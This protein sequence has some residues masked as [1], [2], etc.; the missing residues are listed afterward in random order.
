MKI[1]VKITLLSAVAMIALIISVGLGYNGIYTVSD[2]FV[3]CGDV[4]IKNNQAAS[5]IVADLRQV[6]TLNALYYCY[7]GDTLKI[8]EANKEILELTADIKAQLAFLKENISE[9]GIPYIE[10]FEK[11]L[12]LSGAA[13]LKLNDLVAA[14]KW[15]DYLIY[16]I[17]DYKTLVDASIAS[18][19]KYENFTVEN[20]LKFCYV[21]SREESDAVRRNLLI[22]AIISVAVV[23]VASFVI[24]LGITKPLKRA[25]EA[26]VKISVGNLNVDLSTNS[27]DETGI[28][29]H[30]LETMKVIIEEVING[31]EDMSNAALEGDLSKR[32]NVSKMKGAWQEM[33]TS[34]NKLVTTVEK[35]FN[36]VGNVLETMSTGDL[37]LRITSDYQGKFKDMKNDINNLGDSLTDLISQLQEAIHTTASA[38]SEISTT[39]ETIATATQNQSSQTDEV[40]GAVEEMSRTVTENADSALKTAEVAKQSGEVANDGGNIVQQTVMKMRE[41]S[42]VVKSSAENIAKL[43]ESSKKIGEIINVINGIAKQT[44]LLSLNAA[45][46]AARAG[47]QGKGFA[48]VANSVSKLSES[49]AAATREISDMIK[50]IQ[51]DTELAVQA[52]ETGTIEVESGIELADKA[53]NSL[54]NILTNINELLDMVNHIAA[55]SEEQSATSKQISK[56]I[57]SISRVTAESAKNVEDVASTANKLAKMTETLTTLISQF[58]VNATHSL[59]GHSHS[60]SLKH[61]SNK[62]LES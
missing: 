34:L 31:T 19:M 30:S 52:M 58:K 23:I 25:V 7:R 16:R 57:T 45:I 37:T 54:H 20:A 21:T 28:L 11:K 3:Y 1:S 29:L 12:A 61:R 13:R 39:A 59:H 50:E 35:V 32:I 9:E 38:S 8:H 41:I 26:A 24:I 14:G 10:D 18:M 22:I 36:E 60:N 17:G 6:T 49:T 48:V 15:D 2:M 53:G 56:N 5:K 62:Y 40:A 4:P 55:A 47:E 33:A 43:G 51:T 46:E 42:S 44:N 27:K